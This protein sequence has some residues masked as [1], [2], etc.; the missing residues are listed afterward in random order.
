MNYKYA[1]GNTG[2]YIDEPGVGWKYAHG[3]TGYMSQH[4]N[5]GGSKSAHGNTGGSPI[6]N[7]GKGI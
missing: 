2:Y 7:H 1:D 3:D 4:G 5:G 6:K